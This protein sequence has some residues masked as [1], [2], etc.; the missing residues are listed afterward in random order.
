MSDSSYETDR[1]RPT[2]EAPDSRTVAAR[3]AAL[4]HP[5]RIEILKHLSTSN[6]CCCREVVDRFDLAQSTVSQHLKILVDAGLVRFE[7]DRQRSRYAVDH[8][9]LTEISASLAA[10][11]NS[12]CSGR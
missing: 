6:F 5:A 9:A 1:L 11:V 4:S 10:L 2:S 12:C 7:P 3:L 8:V